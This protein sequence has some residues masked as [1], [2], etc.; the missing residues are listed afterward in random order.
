LACHQPLG[1]LIERDRKPVEAEK[2]ISEAEK[3]I[4]DLERK[5]ALRQQNSETSS[6]TPSSDGL[7]G[8]QRQR[9]RKTGKSRL[10][11]GGQSGHRGHWRGLAPP[12]RVDRVIDLLP[13]P[14]PALRVQ[15]QW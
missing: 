14:L 12:D 4:A 7:A 8:E 2:Q 9:G 6:K 1:R 10:K 11:P 15:F 5:L 3:Q 13:A